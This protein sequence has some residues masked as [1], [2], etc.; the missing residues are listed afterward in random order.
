[1][2]FSPEQARGFYRT[3]SEFT[4]RVRER[5][6]GLVAMHPVHEDTAELLLELMKKTPVDPAGIVPVAALDPYLSLNFLILANALSVDRDNAVGTVPDAI[7]RIG[8]GLDRFGQDSV[9]GRHQADVQLDGAG[10]A[11]ALELA[12]LE[13]AQQLGLQ[14]RRQLADLVEKHGPALGRSRAC[15]SSARPRR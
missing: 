15:P 9:S 7:Q 1:M 2:I 13:D 6:R 11:H 12:F 5:A 4:D 14:Q 8:E 10:A 3:F